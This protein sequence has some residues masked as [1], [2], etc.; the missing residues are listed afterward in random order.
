MIENE[1]DETDCFRT[2]LLYEVQTNTDYISSMRASHLIQGECAVLLQESGDICLLTD[3]CI[4]KSFDDP[5]LIKIASGL[6]PKFTTKNLW[7]SVHFG[8]QPRQF[9]YSDC[10]QVVSIDSR[11]KN[12]GNNLNN[13]IFKVS[14]EYLEFDELISRTQIADNDFYCHL[15]CCSKTFVVIDERYTKQ[16]VLSWKHNLKSS[17]IFLEDLYMPSFSCTFSNNYWEQSS[18][19]DCSHLALISDACHT[20]S[21]QYS[22][23]HNMFMSFNFPLKLDSP[24]DMVNYFPES[25]D[26]RLSNH[27]KSRLSERLVG[28]SA[29][30]YSNSFAL[31]QVIMLFLKIRPF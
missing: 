15:I 18:S 9:I 20:Y 12:L 19:N 13:E 6:K 26:K 28:F 27:I 22:T 23:K 4:V 16:P 10:S 5:A 25:Y 17:A 8:A 7:K 21:F 29:L 1:T 2:K 24:I 14:L 11:I 30:K 3:E 31:F